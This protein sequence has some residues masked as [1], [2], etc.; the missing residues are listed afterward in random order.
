M[1]HDADGVIVEVGARTRTIPAALRRA[2]ASRDHGCRFPGCELP[3]GQAHHIQHSA[4]GGPTTLSNLVLL[5]RRHHRAVHEE[6]FQVARLENGE[7]QFRWPNGRVLSEVPPPPKTPHDAAADIR[8]KNT[9]GGISVHLHTA[10][11][12][13][14]GES[15]N[16]G[17]AIDVLHPLA[18]PL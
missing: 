1:R 5:C 13:W 14:Y 12:G 2:L 7:L 3:F 18:N 9:A 10:T 4:Q 17:W 8:A 15:L 11:P 6:G 16:V